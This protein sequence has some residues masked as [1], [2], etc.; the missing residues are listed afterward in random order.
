MK[1]QYTDKISAA[2]GINCVVYGAS[3]VGKTCLLAS[4]PAPFIFSAESGLL[5]LRK[6]RIPYADVSTYKELV[7]AIGWYQSSKEA[8]SYQS[9]GIDSL[10]EISEVLLAEELKKTTDPRKAYGNMQQSMY[11][12]VRL[13]RDFPGRNKINIAKQIF[14]QEGMVRKAI[15]LMPSEKLQAQLPY[16]FDL[17]LQLYVGT[18]PNNNKTYR[19]INTSSGPTWEGKDRSGS[20]DA[21]EYPDLSNIFAKAVS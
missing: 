19:A 8:K 6:L 20:L 2:D 3:G 1:I 5:S 21:V 14:V 13:I 4:A 17:V 11:A 12:L 16:F 18:D 9:F 7:D 10:S 15:P